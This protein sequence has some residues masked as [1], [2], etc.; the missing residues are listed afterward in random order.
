MRDQPTNVAY[1][2]KRATTAAHQRPERADH[3]RGIGGMPAGQA[4]VKLFVPDDAHHVAK[5]GRRAWKV[6]PQLQGGGD[7]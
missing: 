1:S 4:V 3:Q 6:E 5:D 7:Q 2:I